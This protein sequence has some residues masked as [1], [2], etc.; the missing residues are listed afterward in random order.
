M[1]VVQTSFAQL[2]MFRS[3]IP[4]CLLGLSD[5]VIDPVGV[6]NEGE[7]YIRSS[8]EIGDPMESTDPFTFLGDVLVGVI[9]IQ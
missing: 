6:L 2:S 1:K 5:S 4:N 8:K 7:I 3:F 9:V